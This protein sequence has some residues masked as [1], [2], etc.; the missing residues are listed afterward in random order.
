MRLALTALLALAATPA[1][2]QSDVGPGTANPAQVAAGTYAIDPLHSQ[3]LFTVKHM[4]FTFYSGQFTEPTGTL[5]L[6]PKKPAADKVDISFPTNK[7]VTTVAHLNEHLASDQFLDS[8]KFP[9]ARFVSTKVTVS[10]TKATIAG[11]L[12][13]HGVTRPVVLDARFVGGGVNPMS[14]KPTIGFQATTTIKRSDYGVTFLADLVSDSVPLT[15]NAAFEA[16]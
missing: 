6:D 7:A 15:I 3:V 4:G 9:T 11:T 14:K 2:A 5:V 1:L 10:G 12:T 13:L 16:Q 8:A